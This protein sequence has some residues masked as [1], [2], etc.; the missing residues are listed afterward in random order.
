[1]IKVFLAH[2]WMT[3]RELEGLT[4]EPPYIIG[5]NGHQSIVQPDRFGWQPEEAA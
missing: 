3:W 4:T 5:R 1:M 2:L